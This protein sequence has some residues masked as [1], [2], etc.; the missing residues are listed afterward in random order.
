M[1]RVE[2]HPQAQEEFISAARFYEANAPNLGV[3][4]I[5]SVRHT[6]STLLEF[7]ERGRRFGGR[8]RRALVPGFPYGLLYKAESERS[9]I[10]AVAHLSRRP[11][12]WRDRS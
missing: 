10:V 2:F 7:P 8:L 12:Y 5:R 6:A 4:F 9:Y 3:T 11:G 1:R